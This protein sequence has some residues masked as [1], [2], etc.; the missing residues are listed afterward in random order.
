MLLLNVSAFAQNEDRLV[1]IERE[2]N[3]ASKR[4]PALNN[5]VDFTANNYTLQEVIRAIASDNDLNVVVSP[6]LTELVT[7]NFS[8]VTAKEVFLLFAKQHNV[9]IEW[10]GNIM[11]F[12]KVV[13]AAPA[14][15]YK[16]VKPINIAYDKN[17]GLVEADLSGDT[18]YFVLKKLASISGINIGVHPDLHNK[19]V[20]KHI[21][22]L[23][24]EEALKELAGE[25]EWIKVSDNFY[26]INPK[27]AVSID[28]QNNKSG[29]N[30]GT[31]KNTYGNQKNAG[32]ASEGEI[33][34]EV[35][36][37]G[38][39]S[40]SASNALIADVI[41][42]MSERIGVNYYMSKEPTEKT[43]VHIVGRNYDEILKILFNGTSFTFT[44][45]NGIFLIG[46]RSQE[47]LRSTVVV[48]LQ[49]R[50]AEDM[51]DFIPADLKKNLEVLVFTEQN[52]LILSGS[53]PQIKELEYLIQQLD[54]VVPVILIEVMIV[55]ISKTNNTATGVKAGF[56]S[57]DTGKPNYTFNT[58]D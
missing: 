47:G 39:I 31:N 37:T 30:K 17:S 45:L 18:L 26:K 48:Q 51:K 49:H 3:E 35:L 56:K 15:V 2:L 54:K 27:K 20:Q 41:K 46:D 7:Y 55:D 40:L 13:E 6:N 5:T 10:T 23:P 43:T 38:K 33:E 25:E 4:I 19:I 14:I 8:N 42:Q 16:A 34:I 44:E 22:S 50:I 9:N 57:G 21:V 36:S 28:V 58:G 52:S 32:T 29:Y 1:R 11:S 24:F 12:T 53:E